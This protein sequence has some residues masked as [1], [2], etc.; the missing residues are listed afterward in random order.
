LAFPQTVGTIH[1]YPLPEL[2]DP[3]ERF[4]AY[5]A[6]DKI[7][8]LVGTVKNVASRELLCRIE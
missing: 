8:R 2:M 3:K 7:R 6:N 4:S 5:I 1:S